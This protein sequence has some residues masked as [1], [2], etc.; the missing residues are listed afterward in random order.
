[1]LQRIQTIFLLLCVASF[2]LLYAF[3]FAASDQPGKEVM[4]DSLYTIED[5]IILLILAGLGALIAVVSIFRFKHRPQQIRLNYLVVAIAIIFLLAGGWFFYQEGP[6]WLSKVTLS[7]KA[8]AFMPLGAVIFA[9]L[10]N[11]YIRK[12][13]KKVRSAYDRLR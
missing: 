5:H 7:Y 1:M 3:P 8:G 10:A 13:H 11:R 4:A 6:D 2:G 9:L 12:D